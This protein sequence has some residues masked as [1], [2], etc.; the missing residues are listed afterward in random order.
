[1]FLKMEGNPHFKGPQPKGLGPSTNGNSVLYCVLNL[2]VIIS[3]TVIGRRT[4]WWSWLWERV[5]WSYRSKMKM[6]IITTKKAHYWWPY[7]ELCET[8]T[9]AKV[10]EPFNEYVKQ[11]ES[12]LGQP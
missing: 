7:D 12:N 3:S 5:W 11:V 6:K 1:M 2:F 4:Q 9:E 10:Y 8:V